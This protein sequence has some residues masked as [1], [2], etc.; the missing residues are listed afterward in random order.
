MQQEQPREILGKRARMSEVPQSKPHVGPAALRPNST[1]AKAKPSTPK[2]VE[3]KDLAVS[4]AATQE[5]DNIHHGPDAA[6]RSG[7]GPTSAREPP[8]KRR[9]IHVVHIV[10]PEIEIK[11]EE[12]PSVPL[13]DKSYVD[14]R[15]TEAGRPSS[16]LRCRAVEASI[17]AAKLQQHTPPPSPD[18]GAP[19]TVAA[20]S[21]TPSATAN[22]RPALTPPRFFAITL[23]PT[24]PASPLSSEPVLSWPKEVNDFDS[25][26][27]AS[28]STQSLINHYLRV[29]ELEAGRI[30]MVP[31]LEE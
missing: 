21:S 17:T 20:S 6:D 19:E 3:S 12:P 30:A 11:E 29:V 7:R 26:A 22:Q 1:S 10:V 15:M 16:L 5:R 14:A 4:R 28:A 2:P 27:L 24:P 18:S 31:L 25:Y 9:K 8:Q 13:F 23:P